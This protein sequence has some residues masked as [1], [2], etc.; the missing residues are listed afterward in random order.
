MDP[1]C[2][3][4]W[5]RVLEHGTVDQVDRVLAVVTLQER[6]EGAESKSQQ[7]GGV[8]CNFQA[9]TENIGPRV[10]KNTLKNIFFH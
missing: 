7:N 8:R 4:L 6:K 3:L 10:T 2:T 9:V 1:Y 5:L